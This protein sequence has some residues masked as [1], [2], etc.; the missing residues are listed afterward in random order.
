M[1]NITQSR[2]RLAAV[3]VA[4]A[5]IGA[6]L[7]ATSGAETFVSTSE[8]ETGALTTAAK[9]VAG[10]GTSG[11]QSVVFGGQ[12]TALKP[13]I[14]GLLDRR[15]APTGVYQDALGGF[16]VEG[17]WAELQ[18]TQGGEIAANNDI[19][20]AIADIRAINSAKTGRDLQLKIRLFTGTSAPAWAKN[21]DGAN[22]AV[23]VN[24]PVDGGTGTVGRFWNDAFGN[25]YDDFVSKMAAKYDV[26][27]E[28]RE[29]TVARCMTVYAEPFIRQV[30]SQETVASLLAAGYTVA[31]DKQCHREQLDSHKVWSTTRSSIALNPYQVVDNDS[32][33]P[34]TDVS[35]TNEMANYC[36]QSL[37]Q[38]C[39][40]ENNSIG[41]PLKSSGGYTSMYSTII[42][43]GKPITFQTETACKIE[44]WRGTLD[45]ALDTAHAYA[46]ELPSANCTKDGVTYYGYKNAAT[47]P[48]SELTT[49]NNRF[50]AQP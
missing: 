9:V 3:A 41:W 25:A 8:A 31:K 47:Y 42:S 49:Y 34:G 27:P 19:D 24:D 10:T 7:V 45:W 28:I 21:L 20:K 5:A 23:T 50:R 22:T 11:G 35:F 30:T 38:R 13:P 14:K 15:S 16:V 36:R 39:V 32:Q 2:V 48:V 29:V 12:E 6:A 44:D 46:V 17:R 43:L 4:F 33:T 40:L 1:I 18:T 37:G 26:V